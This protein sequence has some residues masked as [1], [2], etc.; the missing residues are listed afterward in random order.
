MRA[1]AAASAFDFEAVGACV[2]QRDGDDAVDE[3][4]YKRQRADMACSER[5]GEGGAAS[6]MHSYESSDVEISGTHHGPLDVR[7]RLHSAFVAMLP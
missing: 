5:S 6:G 4:P 3:S 7:A 1:D 2:R